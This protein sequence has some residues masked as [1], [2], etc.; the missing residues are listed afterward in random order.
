MSVFLLYSGIRF[1]L[2]SKK[3]KWLSHSNFSDLKQRRFNDF[4]VIKGFSSKSMTYCSTTAPSGRA[5]IYFFFFSSSRQR[6]PLIVKVWLGRSCLKIPVSSALKMFY[7][8]FDERIFLV[9]LFVDIRYLMANSFHCFC[10]GC[11]TTT[12]CWLKSHFVRGMLQAIELLPSVS[13]P[14]EYFVTMCLE[15]R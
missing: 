13:G 3:K 10:H 12:R 15:T 2:V 9:L 8:L 1:G 5:E 7:L 6:S 11:G 14:L 4:P